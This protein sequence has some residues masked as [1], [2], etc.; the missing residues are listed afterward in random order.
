MLVSRAPGTSGRLHNF[1]A[2]HDWVGLVR[3]KQ[4]W[5]MGRSRSYVTDFEN[6][7]LQTP[8]YTQAPLLS[9]GSLQV[10]VH[11]KHRWLDNGLRGVIEDLIHDRKLGLANKF[12]RSW[13][14]T[15]KIEPGIGIHWRIEKSR[16][17]A[18][19]SLTMAEARRPCEAE[20]WRDVFEIGENK[21]VAEAVVTHIRQICR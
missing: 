9:V 10:C 4:V 15:G 3:I 5:Q 16:P 18:N 19:H 20:P 13:S 1:V 7:V 2:L 14:I 21:I 17:A 11:G 8:L 6:Q 12:R